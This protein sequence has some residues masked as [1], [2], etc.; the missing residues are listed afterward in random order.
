MEVYISMYMFVNFRFIYIFIHIY[1]Y[2]L[3]IKV[4][5]CFCVLF[6]LFIFVFALCTN[7]STRFLLLVFR[8]L[9]CECIFSCMSVGTLT[10]DYPDRKSIVLNFNIFSVSQWSEVRCSALPL[11][12]LPRFVASIIEH[13]DQCSCSS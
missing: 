13:L 8:V 12:H 3:Y 9:Y 10:L 11:P 5:N 2:I 1:T 7:L 4:Q 6:L